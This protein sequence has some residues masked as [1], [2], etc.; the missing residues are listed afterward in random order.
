MTT[1]N[2]LT[3]SHTVADALR[4]YVRTPFITNRLTRSPRAAEPYL[5]IASAH[6]IAA[7]Q[8]SCLTR[9][10]AAQFRDELTDKGYSSGTINGI[11]SK[12]RQLGDKL[13][14]YELI[15]SNYFRDIGNAAP[16]ER[17]R[18]TRV[19]SAEDIEQI[20]SELHD[21]NPAYA[22]AFSF[23]L[24]TAMRLGE[25]VGVRARDVQGNKLWVPVSLDK[26]KRGRWVYLNAEA[27]SVLQR[28]GLATLLPDDLLFPYEKGTLRQA[29]WR[30]RVRLG[31]P[32]FWHLSRHT[33]I[34]NAA[35]CTNSVRELMAFSGHRTVIALQGY[36]HN[37]SSDLDAAVLS[38]LPANLTH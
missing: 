7:V 31:V 35:G 2:K 13:V 4:A 37:D 38:A 15:P 18:Q 21:A 8:L 36:L 17:K 23:S 1:F 30:V 34:S 6:S 10:V 25:V 11:I 26:S 19:L 27:Q 9:R 12:L 3:S 5:N 28:Q 22:D 16:T 20:V 33:A 29:M 24:Q 14:D 32:V